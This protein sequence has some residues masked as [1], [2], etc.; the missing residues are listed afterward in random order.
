MP[1]S[2]S[3]YW[4]AL[5]DHLRA[6]DNADVVLHDLGFDYFRAIR[7]NGVPRETGTRWILPHFAVVAT[8]RKQRVKAGNRVELVIRRPYYGHLAMHEQ[9]IRQEI[10]HILPSDPPTD[11][12]ETGHFE[13][14]KPHNLEREDAWQTDFEWFVDNLRLFEGVLAPRVL[15]ALRR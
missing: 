10:P 14:W 12:N 13:V 11:H 8:K 6:S 5:E 3:A 2:R 15:A 9:R 1:N 4:R 7:I